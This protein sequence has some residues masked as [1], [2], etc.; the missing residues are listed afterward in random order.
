MKAMILAAGKGTRVQPLTYELPKPMIPILG[1]PVMEYLIEH[2]V[3]CG[4]REIMVNVSHLH[5]K[6]EDYFGDGHRFGCEIGYSFEGFMTEDGELHPEP[7][8]SAGGMKKIHEFGRFFDETTL[9]ICGD[10]I[11]DLDIAAA[12]AEHRSKGAAASIITKDVP[13]EKTAEYGVVVVDPD[14]RVQSFQE[15]PKPADAL[16]TLVST[17]IYIFEPEIIDL[18]PSRQTFDIGSELFPL[19]LE[20]GVPF[21]AQ[22]RPFDWIDIGNVKDF[23]SVSQSVLSGEV[24]HMIVPGTEI[25]PGIWVGLNVNIDWTDTTITGPVYLGSGTRVDAGSTITGP[26]WIGHGSHICTGAD[27][28]QCILFEYTRITVNTQMTDMVVCKDYC[29]NREGTMM[30]LSD[31]PN[32]RWSDAR[33]RRNAT[34][35]SLDLSA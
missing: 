31:S 29:V 24:E 11:I 14:G 30:H 16:S 22:S 35:H 2:L 10:A 13:R 21:Y 33:D 18:I 3:R 4:I 1:K 8:G 6:I 23:W 26:T 27:I 28:S 32:E 12:L 7:V 19:L 15:K 34:R 5:R 9:V 25:R 20:K 17:G